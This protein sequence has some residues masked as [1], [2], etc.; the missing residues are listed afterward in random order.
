MVEPQADGVAAAAVGQ[1]LRD[2][3][4]PREGNAGRE[5][6]LVK[7]R[8]QE[9][10]LL[11]RRHLHHADRPPAEDAGERQRE[12][13][14]VPVGL[15]ALH[16]VDLVQ[17]DDVEEVPQADGEA[18]QTLLHVIGPGAAERHGAVVPLGREAAKERNRGTLEGPR[19]RRVQVAADIDQGSAG[20]SVEFVVLV[21]VLVLVV[22]IVVVVGAPQNRA[23]K[24]V[25][26]HVVGR[27]RGDA[28]GADLEV[29][30]PVLA[31]RPV[32]QH[33]GRGDLEVLRADA[34]GHRRAV[35]V[36]V[37]VV[38]KEGDGEAVAVAGGFPRRLRRLLRPGP[39]PDERQRGK[40]QRHATP[41]GRGLRCSHSHRRTCLRS[42]RPR[43]RG[44]PR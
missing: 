3:F 5:D 27:R 24:P 29:E 17:V 4:P 32:D 15:T 34:A 10:R 37:V 40:Q 35:A 6:D 11:D 13:R 2:D 42:R 33:G 7:R 38:E 36:L 12:I 22:I 31:D 30:P 26:V 28:V 9:A 1:L 18:A 8:R 44:R 39:G 25:D 21:V 23:L 43:P 16:A 14:R 41:Q 19:G 20:G